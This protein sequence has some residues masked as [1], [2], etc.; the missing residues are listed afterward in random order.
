MIDA[1]ARRARRS[2]RLCGELTPEVARDDLERLGRIVFGKNEHRRPK[3]MPHL[4]RRRPAL[5]GENSAQFYIACHTGRFLT[6]MGRSASTHMPRTKKSLTE[7]KVPKKKSSK[8]ASKTTSSPS[9]ANVAKVSAPEAKRWEDAPP[10]EVEAEVVRVIRAEGDQ[11]RSDLRLSEMNIDSD[12]LEI[13]LEKVFFAEM[14]FLELQDSDTSGVVV[15]KVQAKLDL[16]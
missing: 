16:L 2:S 11:Y 8:K 12:S 6:C 3:P 7:K 4:F 1:A 9:G 10:S 14:D 15:A 5:R 13:E